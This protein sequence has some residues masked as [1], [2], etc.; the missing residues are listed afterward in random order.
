[1]IQLFN[2]QQDEDTIIKSLASVIKKYNKTNQELT[3]EQ[4]LSLTL[5]KLNKPRGKRSK[6]NNNPQQV[7]RIVA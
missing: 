6:A 3:N 4:A 7:K 5:V 2:P 1:M